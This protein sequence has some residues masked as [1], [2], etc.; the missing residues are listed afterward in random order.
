[1]PSAGRR[2]GPLCMWREFGLHIVRLRHL[3]RLGLVAAHNAAQWHAR[4][5]KM[6]QIEVKGEVNKNPLHRTYGI[7]SL[8]LK[9]TWSRNL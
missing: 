1:M 4:R 6:S 7:Q 8:N 5:L 2:L 9:C 3:L